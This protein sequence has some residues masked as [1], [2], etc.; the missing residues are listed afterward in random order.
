MAQH[1]LGKVALV[2]GGAGG[3]GS[4]IC[5][6]YAEQGAKVVVCDTGFDVEGRAGMDPSK[7]QAVVDE[8]AAAGGEA[9]AIAGDIADMDTAER[10]VGAAI[11]TYGDLDILV[12]AHGILRERMVFNMSEEEWDGLVRVHLKGCFAPTKFA[13]IHWRANRDKGNRRIIYFTSSA[14]VRGEAGQPNYSAAHAG[15]IGLSL[16][17]AEALERYGATS[18]CISPSASTRMTD[19]ELGVDQ[20]APAPSLSAAGSLMDPANV[21]PVAVYLASDAS[22]DISG[23]VVGSMGGRITIWR[24]PEWEQTLWHTEPY[25]DIDT[26]FETIPHTFALQGLGPPPPQYP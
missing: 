16:S 18:N 6:A 22:A 2:T 10:A 5:K 8:I 9:T 14:G 11:E 26:L 12:C 13:A 17:N 3:M 7:V 24:E 15:K 23:R 25:W 20:S 19:R 1:L 21:T 4:Q